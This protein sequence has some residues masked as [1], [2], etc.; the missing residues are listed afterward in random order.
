MK[1]YI[2]ATTII[3]AAALAFAASGAKTKSIQDRVEEA[4]LDTSKIAELMP[5]KPEDRDRFRSE[6]LSALDKMPASPKERGKKIVAAKKAFADFQEKERGSKVILCPVAAPKTFTGA[7]A[8]EL[9]SS[10][11]NSVA[12]TNIIWALEEIDMGYGL[13]RKP[14]TMD[15]SKKY[16]PGW[17]RGEEPGGYPSQSLR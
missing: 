1:K 10:Q 14:R 11:T 4:A 17:R 5:E 2:L 15:K 7:T 12:A 6:L 8:L 3:M 16:Y 13:D 9:T